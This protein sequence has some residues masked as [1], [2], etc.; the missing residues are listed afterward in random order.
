MLKKIFMIGFLCF[1]TSGF[2][3][4]KINQYIQKEKPGKDDIVVVVFQYPS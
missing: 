4:P 2:A 1:L 3:S